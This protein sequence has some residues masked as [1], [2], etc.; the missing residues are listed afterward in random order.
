MRRSIAYAIVSSVC[1]RLVSGLQLCSTAPTVA[2]LAGAIGIEIL[3][4]RLDPP[5]S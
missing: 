5:Q 1:R 2:S 4:T 3:R